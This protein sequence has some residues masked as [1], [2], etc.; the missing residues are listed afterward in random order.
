MKRREFITLLGGAVM[1][2]IGYLSVGTA[3]SQARGLA[4][5]RQGLGE[6]GYVEGVNVAFELRFANGKIERLPELAAELVR[7]RVAILAAAPRA[8][9]VAKASTSTIPIVFV[10][11]AD[12]LQTGLV[13]SLNRPGGNL[14]GVSNLSEELEAKRFGL[15]H[16]LL[17]SADSIAVLIDRNVRDVRARSVE[18]G[19]GSLG[20]RIEV[21]EVGDADEFETAISGIVHRGHHAVIVA[22]SSYFNVYR[23]RLVT[24]S[25]RY[26]IP[27]MFKTR[28]FTD[29]G[30]LMSYGSDP[31]ETSRQLG[32]YAGRI[33]QGAKPA[34]LPVWEAIKVE[35]ILNLKTARTLGITFPLSLLGRA[36]EVIE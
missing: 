26:R 5:F 2:V 6:L 1:P 9:L 13:A 17:P 3:E 16:E 29:K 34:D 36:D 11:G 21:V 19:A 7:R 31:A 32:L 27:A 12:P 15:L 14:T 4:A 30:G 23:D 24:L 8:D 28:E 18:L 22:G 10:S 33:L 35:L 20:L 25:A